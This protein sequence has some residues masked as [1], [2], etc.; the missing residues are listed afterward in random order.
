MVCT[1]CYMHCRVTGYG[2]HVCMLYVCLLLRSAT[3]LVLPL[4]QKYGLIGFSL[5]I[6]PPLNLL[7][8]PLHAHYTCSHTPSF[9]A[10]ILLATKSMPGERERER[11]R[12]KMVFNNACTCQVNCHAGFIRVTYQYYV[13]AF[14]TF[15][16]VR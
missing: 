4:C 2:N 5:A 11:E 8:P 9:L 15:F 6:P 14:I 13:H 16:S 3:Y 12:A 7:L 1:Y 10:P